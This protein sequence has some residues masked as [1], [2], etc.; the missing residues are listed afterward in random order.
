MPYKSKKRGGKST[1]FVIQMKGPGAEFAIRY[2]EMIEKATGIPGEMLAKLSSEQGRH[3]SRYK[4][5]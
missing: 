3:L 4:W 5:C 2:F 1:L